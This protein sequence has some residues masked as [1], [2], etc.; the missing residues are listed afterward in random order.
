VADG[1]GSESPSD[2]KVKRRAAVLQAALELFAER[3]YNETTITQIA[4]RAGMSRRLFFYY[5]NSKD[6]ILFEVSDAALTWLEEVV[7]DQPPELSDLDAAAES[8]KHF[9]G[10]GRDYRNRAQS[11]NLVVQLRRAAESSALL[12]GKE[13]EGHLAYQRAVA[14][15]LARR[16]GLAHPDAAAMTAAAIA[17]TMMHA[18]VDRWVLTE[19]IDRDQLIDEQFALAKAILGTPTGRNGRR[20]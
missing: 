12:R 16:R 3:G 2:A 13:Y 11:R 17:Q 19:G 15:G 20:R 6:D 10:Y 4:E 9:D 7:G 1:G 5:F 14:K 8:W 18:V